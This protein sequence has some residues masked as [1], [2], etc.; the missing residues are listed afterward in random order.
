MSGSG[1]RREDDAYAAAVEGIERSAAR[2]M[3]ATGGGVSGRFTFGSLRRSSA[4]VTGQPPAGG[5]HL[6]FNPDTGVLTGIV[7]AT[8]GEADHAA[9]EAESAADELAAHLDRAIAALLHDF[10]ERLAVANARLDRVIGAET[11]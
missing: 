7:E 2:Y 9:Q 6:D 3:R 8:A 10:D 4:M 5:M 1:S 11:R